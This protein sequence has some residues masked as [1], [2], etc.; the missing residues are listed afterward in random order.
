MMTILGF[1]FI[2]IGAMVAL[3]Y[4]IILV[5]KAFKTSVVW[6]LAYLFV[7]FGAFVFLITHWDE[8]GK[9]F[10]MSM[11]SLPLL[12]IGFTLIPATE[13]DGDDF[14]EPVE[15]QELETPVP[16]EVERVGEVAQATEAVRVA[17]DAQ[18]AGTSEVEAAGPVVPSVAEALVKPPA[19][20]PVAA[21]VEK[22]VG[23]DPAIIAYIE[24][25]SVSG[26]RVAGANSRI[27]LNGKVYYPDSHVNLDLQLKIYAILQD[28]VVFIDGD[29][30]Q[31][32]KGF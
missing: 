22:A 7:P 2:A 14:A 23:G 17:E 30:I 9:P 16:A 15:S 21:P 24:S 18:I 20:A 29:R 25:L 12:L 4:G 27:V 1:V 11:L 13:T 26:V 32:R 8:A 3:V 31:Y 28:E 6:G 19:P 10:L 5:T